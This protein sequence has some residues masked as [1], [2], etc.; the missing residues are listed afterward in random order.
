MQQH[1]RE[2]ITAQA[3]AEMAAAITAII[4]NHELTCGEVLAAL[5]AIQVRW[6]KCQVRDERAASN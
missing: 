3:E 6:A 2:S 5:A 1:P 4:Q